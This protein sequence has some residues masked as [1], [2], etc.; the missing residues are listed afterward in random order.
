MRR[1]LRFT[2]RTNHISHSHASLSGNEHK[3]LKY[4]RTHCR[5]LCNRK[6]EQGNF[7][8]SKSESHSVL[9]D[10]LRSRELYSPWNSP[11][12]NTGVGSLS[13]LQVIFL[14]QE[15]NPGLLQCRQI[16]FQLNHHG[17]PRI[18]EWVAFSFFRGSSRPRN[19]TRVSCIAGGFFTSWAVLI[20]KTITW[21]KEPRKGT[22]KLKWQ[23]SLPSDA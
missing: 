2:I 16:L 4:S 1:G 13:L 17:S 7:N 22:W 21:Q 19:Q 23:E 3:V 9:S 18:P 11:S 10:S 20:Y 5:L 15:S 14:T 8:E 12:W 6:P